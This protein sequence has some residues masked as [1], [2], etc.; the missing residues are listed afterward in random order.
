[1][2]I[3]VPSAIPTLTVGGRVFTDLQN[4]IILKG[5]AQL[6]QN[7]TLR[8]FTGTAGYQVTA[9]KTLQIQAVE[10]QTNSYFTTGHSVFVLQ[11][12]N[13]VGLNTATA[14]TNPVYPF[15]NSTD[16]FGGLN[17]CNDTGTIRSQKVYR[18]NVAAG[19]YVSMVNAAGSVNTEVT[20]FGYEV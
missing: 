11:T 1:M 15:G 8:N 4:L 12:D 5:Y 16:T 17:V 7:A 2:N 14:F 18:F 6:S 20:V 19:K 10:W 9:G 3:V 13:D